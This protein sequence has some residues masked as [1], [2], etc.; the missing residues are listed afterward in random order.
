MKKK[1]GITLGII[2][3]AIVGFLLWKRPWSKLTSLTDSSS[4]SSGRTV[5]VDEASSLSS[6]DSSDSV[7]TVYTGNV[8]NVGS[9]GSVTMVATGS[10]TVTVSPSHFP[11]RYGSENDSVWYFQYLVNRL[12]DAGGLQG[13]KLNTD[14]KW[15]GN[16]ERAA[17][18]IYA[19]NSVLEWNG[20][21][22][23]T[24]D[25]VTMVDE[26]TAESLYCVP[27][28]DALAVLARYTVGIM[29]ANIN[30]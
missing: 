17:S 30:N 7:F 13:S 23:R 3:A 11:L 20:R 12:I 6:S 22:F 15:G 21:T 24:S 25:A 26:S 29:A 2:A 5:T 8:V 4:S 10:K 28:K 1:L 27:T 19:Q 16:T 9:E 18:Y 14:G